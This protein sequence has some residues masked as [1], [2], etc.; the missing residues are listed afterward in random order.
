MGQKPKD[1]HL[2]SE[3]SSEHD[4]GK[5]FLNSPVKLCKFSESFIITMTHNA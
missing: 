1:E 5:R 3:N 2:L 4:E